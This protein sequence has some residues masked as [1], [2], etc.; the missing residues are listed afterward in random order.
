[1][2]ALIQ[3]GLRPADWTVG[4]NMRLRLGLEWVSYGI[5]LLIKELLNTKTGG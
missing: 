5:Q 1:M 3:D 2:G 4:R